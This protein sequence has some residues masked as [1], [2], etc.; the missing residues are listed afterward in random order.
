M[1]RYAIINDHDATHLEDVSIPSLRFAETYPLTEPSRLVTNREFAATFS[2]EMSP[3]FPYK[4]MNWKR[5][6][7]VLSKDWANR[8]RSVTSPGSLCC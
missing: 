3:S 5:D 1:V 2:N 6:E 4:F 8:G 7:P